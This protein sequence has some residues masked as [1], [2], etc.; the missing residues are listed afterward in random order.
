MGTSNVNPSGVAGPASVASARASV[1]A[2]VPG[3]NGLGTS[4]GTGLE[5]L[6]S[7]YTAGIQQFTTG[8]LPYPAPYPITHLKSANF[9]FF[10]FL[11][12]FLIFIDF[13]F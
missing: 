1:V 5:A 3:I 9:I 10:F 6:A 4:A 11:I 12:N 7:A 2:S 13:F 8:L